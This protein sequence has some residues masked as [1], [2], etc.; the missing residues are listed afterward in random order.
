VASGLS[1]VSFDCLFFLLQ[2]NNEEGNPGHS[3]HEFLYIVFLK[4]QPEVHH[5][6]KQKR[7]DLATLVHVPV[8]LPE[9][10]KLAGGADWDEYNGGCGIAA[11]MELGL[12]VVSCCNSFL[13]TVRRD[14]LLVFALP[15]D[16]AGAGVGQRELVHLNTLGDAMPMKFCFRNAF[17]NF[18]TSGH[19][20]FTDCARRL[21]LVT[22]AGHCAVHIIDV[23]RGTHV[24]YVAQPGTVVGPRGVATKGSFV[25]VSSWYY[26][27]REAHA[28]LVCHRASVL[29]ARSEESLDVLN[30]FAL[31][32]IPGVGLM[33]RQSNKVQFYATP[34]AVAKASMSLCKVA[35]MTAVC[36][37]ITY[38]RVNT[39]TPST[40]LTRL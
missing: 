17:D 6:K 15:E 32:L 3:Q 4:R 2:E 9:Y 13:A 16:I 1:V 22:D 8:C 20:A 36:R 25:A 33:V 12:L 18:D 30:S 37:G 40:L 34:D 39:A 14:V 21:L 23:V 35:W 26:F 7:M 10:S 29:V 19:M 31:A 27:Q 11:S 28:V 5:R 24:G 38:V